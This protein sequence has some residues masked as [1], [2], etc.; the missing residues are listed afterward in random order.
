MSNIRSAAYALLGD[1]DQ[2]A[3]AHDRVTQELRANRS[4]SPVVEVDFVDLALSGEDFPQDVTSASEARDRAIRNQVARDSKLKAA[5]K[6]IERLQGEAVQDH[7]DKALTCLDGE[8]QAL[9]A[10][11][12]ETADVLGTLGGVQTIL[13]RG[14]SDQIKKWRQSKNL[15]ERYKDIR[16]TQLSITRQCVDATQSSHVYEVGFL[17]NS[18]DHAAFWQVQRAQAYTTRAAQDNDESV[19]GYNNWLTAFT[20]A[21]YPHKRSVFPV[22]DDQDIAY[23]LDVCTNHELWVPSIGQLTAAWD[24]AN[25][26][27]QP[28]SFDRLQGTEEA[29]DR[30]YEVTGA[31]PATKYTNGG[32][33]GYRKIARPSFKD[34]YVRHVS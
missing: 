15:V 28:I 18:L 2:L 21:A 30:Y 25:S 33:G 17:R 34:S 13:E 23:L 32:R 31:T 3:T 11:V 4:V 8:L 26:T 9:V 16:D 20:P 24:S 22:A 5:K 7:A 6:E 14:S 12:V 27:A 19:S 1:Y 29:R 10:E